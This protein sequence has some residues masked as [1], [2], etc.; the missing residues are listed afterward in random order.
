[1]SL[2]TTGLF[3][4]IC[5]KYLRHPTALHKPGDLVTTFRVVLYKPN[6]TQ[7]AITAATMTN[8]YKITNYTGLAAWD[9]VCPGTWSQIFSTV[10]FNEGSAK[11]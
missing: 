9:A 8:G 5:I 2:C 4:C 3:P 1:M 7:N 11:R 6:K 10:L